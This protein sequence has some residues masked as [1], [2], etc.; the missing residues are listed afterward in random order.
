VVPSKIGKKRKGGAGR[1]K[2]EN[3]SGHLRRTRNQEPEE[4]TGLSRILYE[5]RGSA[6][7]K[8]KRS[9]VQKRAGKKKGTGAIK[10][11]NRNHRAGGKELTNAGKMNP[12]D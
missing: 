11:R 1:C 9:D 10:H 2:G 5:K 6:R 4:G 7:M 12:R 3:L 8:T